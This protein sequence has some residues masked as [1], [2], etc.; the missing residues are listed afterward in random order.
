MAN[1]PSYRAIQ[2]SLE[3]EPLNSLPLL[4][5]IHFC[6]LTGIESYEPLQKTEVLIKILC[7]TMQISLEGKPLIIGQS[8]LI[9][10]TDPLED[11]TKL[12]RKQTFCRTI[13][14]SL[15][16]KPSAGPYKTPQKADPKDIG[17]SKRPRSL[18]RE[19][20]FKTIRY[21]VES[22]ISVGP[23]TTLQKADILQDYAKLLS[24]QTL[25][26]TI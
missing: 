25:F 3:D 12:F 5:K 11:H 1:Q 9:Q 4:E 20:L 14:K 8:K 6:S 16:S 22:R 13:L 7:W 21:S 24:R 18:R 15:E 19:T 10:K 17:P 23:Y 26:K 2:N